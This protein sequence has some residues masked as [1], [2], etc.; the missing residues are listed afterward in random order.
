L[1]P[2]IGMVRRLQPHARPDRAADETKTLS[3]FVIKCRMNE[4]WDDTPT[5]RRRRLDVPTAIFDQLD[6]SS[7]SSIQRFE[8]R[9]SAL[10]PRVNLRLQ[11]SL[12]SR[13]T[14]CVA[15]VKELPEASHR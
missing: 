10:L 7:M 15:L 2:A 6:E 9:L 4:S 1:H 14:D 11:V 8:G 12:K 13:R 3:S 5:R